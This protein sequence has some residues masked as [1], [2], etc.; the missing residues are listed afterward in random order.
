[1][2]EQRVARLRSD[3]AEIK[4]LLKGL[5]NDIKGLV[6]VFAD[7]KGRLAKMDGELSGIGH[8]FAALPSTWTMLAIVFTTWALGSGILIFA[9]NF[10]KR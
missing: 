2:L 6:E 7:V 10:L 9:M 8:R 3:L 4:T 5:S 1:M